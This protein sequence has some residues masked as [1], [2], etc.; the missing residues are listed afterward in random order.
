[1]YI[2]KMP[3]HDADV[4]R[5]VQLTKDG[6]AGGTLCVHLLLADECTCS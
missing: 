3:L 1:M 4:K 6:A 5:I 2:H